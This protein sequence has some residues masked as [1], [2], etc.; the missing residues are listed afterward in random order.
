MSTNAPGDGDW[1]ATI[2][3]EARATRQSG[4]V[5]VFHYGRERPG[6]IPLWVGEGD[7]PT[8]D[9][10]RDVA[11]RALEAGETFYTP[12]RGLPLLREAIATYMDRHYGTPGRFAPD[13]FFVTTGGMQALHIALRMV[14]GG[15]DEVIVPTPAWPNFEGAL[16]I[17]GARTVSVPLEL[18][19][20]QNAMRWGLDPDRVARALTPAT[21]ALV[22]NSPGNPTGWTAS[23]SELEALLALARRHGLWIIA[24]EIY[25]RIFFDG[26]RA[27]SFHDI[28]EKDDRILFV[29]TM[30]K[31][32]AMTGWRVGWLE[33]PA[34]FGQVVEN[35]IQY[36]TSGVPAPSQRAAA[37]ALAEGEAFLARQLARLRTSR[38][39]LCDG[40]AATGRARFARPPGSFYLFC[41][42]EGVG[43]SRASALRIVDEANVGLAPGTAFGAGGEQFM[44]ICFARDPATISQTIVRLGLWL[45]A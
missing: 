27:A 28:M 29:Q 32:W 40:L 19:G 7:L 33:A 35:L 23:P 12:Q 45:K 38:D 15:G 16:T 14:A 21:R 8:P 4:I 2:R 22:I 44:R 34:A 26:P 1:L 39:L 13:Q 20:T 41:A 3:T 37:V 6:L 36:S 43:D 5:E 10:I 31:N 9:F 17:A 42:F 11:L 30:S 24:D 18:A 25:G